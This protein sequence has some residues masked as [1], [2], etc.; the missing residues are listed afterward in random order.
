MQNRQL[1]KSE[2]E[3]VEAVSLLKNCTE[4]AIDTESNGMYAYKERVCLI[5]VATADHCFII[6]TLLIEDMTPLDKIMSDRNV[7]KILHGSDYDLRCLNRD[8]GF[9]LRSLFDTQIGA[10]FLGDTRPNLGSVLDIYLDVQI[11]KSHKL[12]T[13]N[14]GLRPL[15]YEALE[16]AASDVEHLIDLHEELTQRL[17]KLDRYPWVYEECQRLEQIKY[18]EPLAPDVAFLN[19]RGSKKLTPSGLAILKGLF[20]WR[21]T[22]A[23]VKDVPPSRILTNDDLIELCL[24]AESLRS[25]N[26]VTILKVLTEGARVNPSIPYNY[27]DEIL[28]ILV[29]A[30]DAPEVHRPEQRRI[31]S[32]KDPEA[33]DRLHL[34]KQWRQNR[35][36]CLSLDPSLIWPVKS[37]ERIAIETDRWHTEV[38]DLENS[39]VRSWQVK[40]FSEELQNLILNPS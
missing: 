22:K 11:K 38:T 25:T 7:L 9:N 24:Q 13:S 10:R 32:F 4:I 16:Y 30:V 35:A 18:V 28:D 39:S 17:E 19:L 21:D 29:Q 31:N 14:W 20:L 23:S 34:L 3:L 33:K 5:Q 12:Q 36:A 1:V 37:L 2:L 40:E 27:L 6:D 26:R 8:Y 15:S